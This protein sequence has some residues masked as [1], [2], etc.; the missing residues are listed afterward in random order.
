MCEIN[1]KFLFHL[2]FWPDPDK[3][4]KILNN[5]AMLK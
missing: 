5:I 4:L 2:M 3:D 1:V